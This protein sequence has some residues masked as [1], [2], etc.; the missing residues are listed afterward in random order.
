MSC[1]RA[2]LIVKSLLINLLSVGII[3]IVV[4]KSKKK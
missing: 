4:D 1:T 2:I 3:L